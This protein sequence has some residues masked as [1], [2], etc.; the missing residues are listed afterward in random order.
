V[1][2]SAVRWPSLKEPP[3]RASVAE[4]EEGDTVTKQS[5]IAPGKRGIPGRVLGE[6]MQFV[7]SVQVSCSCTSST[8]QL[9]SGPHFGIAR[10][11]PYSTRD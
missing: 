8:G 1:Q 7:C 11:I 9:P 10:P 5:D 4:R 2:S 6:D 3:I